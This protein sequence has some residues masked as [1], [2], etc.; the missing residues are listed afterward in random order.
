M[1]DPT[2]LAH[3]EASIAQPPAALG[4]WVWSLAP[5]GRDVLVA[6]AV[7]VLQPAIDAWRAQAPRLD[8]VLGSGDLLERARDAALAALRAHVADA[9]ER[10]RRLAAEVDALAERALALVDEASGGPTGEE[11]ACELLFCVADAARA[12][13]WTPGEAARAAAGD[14]RE[15]AALVA[16]GPALPAA[17]AVTRFARVCP[18]RAGE[19]VAWV[20]ATY[21]LTAGRP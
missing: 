21:R 12:A 4:P 8:A 14:P 18:E 5:L 1:P 16:A 17:D 3:L 2:V 20:A 7:A 15:E 10:C 11:R 19:V 6:A 9:A 13:G